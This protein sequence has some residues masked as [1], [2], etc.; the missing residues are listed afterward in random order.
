M[1]SARSGDI[2]A[3]PAS[4]LGLAVVAALLLGLLA[5]VAAQAASKPLPPA[6]PAPK[7]ATPLD[8]QHHMYS[9]D[10]YGGVHPLGDA[11]ALASAAYWPGWDIARSVAIFPDGTGGYLLDGY[12]GLH[13][14]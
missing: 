5:G 2:G 14:V 11:P 7:L 13:P 8:N 10:A 1:H 12:G 9:L 6:Q 4:R 3:R